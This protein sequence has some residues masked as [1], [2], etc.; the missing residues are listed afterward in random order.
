[1]LLK[2]VEA[3]KSIPLSADEFAPIFLKN[4]PDV[5]LNERQVADAIRRTVQYA[6]QSQPPPDRAATI[7]L[8]QLKRGATFWID[9]A[10][11][12]RGYPGVPWYVFVAVDG[13]SRSAF[14]QPLKRTTAA[15]AA[16]ALL[17]IMRRFGSP[18]R[19][20]ISD[21]GTEVNF[22]INA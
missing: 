14:Y 12:A 22:I 13:F 3:W 16:R 10:H 8:Y 11:F 19:S 21:K 7:S 17:Q 4:N 18:I 5:A 9:T 15:S 6:S 20:V 2:I 1:M